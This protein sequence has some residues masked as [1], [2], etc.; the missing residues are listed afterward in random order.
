[1]NDKSP[2]PSKR[3]LTGPQVLDR[4]GGRSTM[5]LWRRMH[6]DPNFPR[7]TVI[8]NRNYFDEGELDAYDA[9]AR[10]EAHHANA[11]AY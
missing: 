1:M 6:F 7:P 4:Y 8:G 10:R 2:R 5:W 3:Y 9:S 11:T